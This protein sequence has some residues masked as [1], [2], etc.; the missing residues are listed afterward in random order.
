MQIKINLTFYAFTEERNVSVIFKLRQL[1]SIIEKI[2]NFL[3]M[4][5]GLTT[6]RHYFL[7]IF[8]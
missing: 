2:I 5:I 8:W 3:F 7:L 6:E 4:L 1:S